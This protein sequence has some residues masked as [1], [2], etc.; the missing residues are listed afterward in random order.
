MVM[1]TQ[2]I[3]V[4]VDGYSFQPLSSAV[5][6]AV[7]MREAL[8]RPGGAGIPPLVEPQDVLLFA[9]PIAGNQV[10][11]SSQPATRDAILAALRNHYVAED[12]VDRLIFYFAGHG[13]TASRNGRTRESLILPS[14]VASPTDGRNMICLD[15]LFDLFSER[16]PL[17]QLWIVDACRDM[18]NDRQPRGFDIEWNEEPPQTLRAQVGIHAV[19]PGGKA[20]SAVGGHGRFTQH[21]LDALKGKGC[22]A[23]FIPGRGHFVTGPSVAEY[24]KLRIGEALEGFDDWTRA[25]QKPQL[26]AHGPALEPLLEVPPPPARE[27]AVEIRP[28]QARD[29][30]AIS[31]EVQEGIP[32]PGWPP[33][34]PPRIYEL[35]AKL[36]PNFVPSGWGDPEPNRLAVDLRERTTAIVSV[37]RVV[38]SHLEALRERISTTTGER[39]IARA[40]TEEVCSGGPVRGQPGAPSATLH[41]K[42]ADALARLRLRRAEYPWTIVENQSPNVDFAIDDGVWDLEVLLGDQTIGATRMV[43]TDGERRVVSAVAQITP[44]TAAVLPPGSGDSIG[45]ATPRTVMPSE[46]IGPM[47]GAILP[48]LLPL[49]ALKPFDRENRILHQFGHLAVPLLDPGQ[50]AAHSPAPYAISIAVEGANNPVGDSKHSNERLVWTSGEGRLSVYAGDQRAEQQTVDFTVGGVRVNIAAPR[51][52]GGVSVLTATTW[53]DGR[54]DLTVGIFSLPLGLSWPQP[55][56]GRADFPVGRLT[57]ALALVT[58]LF[59]AGSDLSAVS[60]QL[61]N[62]IAWSKWL[63]PVLG[64]IAFHACQGQI[65]ARAQELGLPAVENLKSMRNTI[66]TNMARFFPQLP[67]S[68]IIAAIHDDPEQ[69]KRQMSLLL[70]DAFLCQPVLSATLA[71]LARAADDAS[72]R[73]HWSLDRFERVRPGQVFNAVLTAL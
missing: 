15:D 22:A 67:D 45:S 25:V 30:V 6:D 71:V 20:L 69:T 5:N 16:G 8:T 43:L 66:Q 29:A 54:L 39:G 13:L 38:L 31:L 21:L 12:P 68:Q 34:A 24:V 73:D 9:T 52:D 46:T 49:L 26:F 40:E 2:A 59:R 32:V 72:R 23:D 10:P 47:Q 56:G 64:A 19:A 28:P 1:K 14:D 55:W 70:D 18:P 65:D 57:R 4:G 35:R 33:V 63:D 37:P 44:A 36:L 11:E 58:P 3:L 17:E 53:P 51:I 50:P 41:V 61:L 42:T 27:F 7:A 60:D 48:T 62:E